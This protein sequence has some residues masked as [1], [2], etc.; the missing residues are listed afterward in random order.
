MNILTTRDTIKAVAERWRKQDEGTADTAKVEIGKRLDAM[1]ARL[2]TVDDVLKIIGNDSWTVITCDEC[3]RDVDAVVIVGA[4]QDY[5]SATASLCSDCIAKAARM[6]LES[7]TQN[8][9]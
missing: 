8:D 3:K 2:A 5:E 7:I 4:P 9:Q 6:M 1:D